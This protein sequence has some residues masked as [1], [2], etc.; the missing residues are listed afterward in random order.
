MKIR[1]EDDSNNLFGIA[2]S[3]VLVSFISIFLV[4]FV[5]VAIQPR[6]EKVNKDQDSLGSICAEITWPQSRRVDLDLWGA[7]PLETFSVG[8]SNMHGENLDLYRDSLGTTIDDPNIEV[9][10]AKKIVPGEWTFNVNYFSD[11]ESGTHD[12]N[13][14]IKMKLRVQPHGKEMEEFEAI[15][16]N[17]ANGEEKTMFDFR[18][19][20]TG[21][22]IKSS[23]NS[24]FRHLRGIEKVN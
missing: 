10:C 9:M 19:D 15:Y 23:I 24:K 2:F 20:E 8:Y 7:S 18:V 16:D 22:I 12:S 11:H 17:L 5:L 14:T 6:S 13:I 1:E 21:S 3:D 4:L